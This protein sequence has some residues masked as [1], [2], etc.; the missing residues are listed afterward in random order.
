MAKIALLIGVSE[1]QAGFT[2]LPKASQDLEAMQR[3][4]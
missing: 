1:Y 3:A 4:L 2:P